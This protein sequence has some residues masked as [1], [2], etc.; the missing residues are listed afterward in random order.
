MSLQY[1]PSFISFPGRRADSVILPIEAI[2]NLLIIFALLWTSSVTA[3]FKVEDRDSWTA[4]SSQGMGTLWIY[5]AADFC[6][7]FHFPPTNSYFPILILN[8]SFAFSTVSIRVTF[9]FSN[10][11]SRSHSQIA[12]V[13]SEHIIF[14]S[15]CQVCSSFVPT[16]TEFNL[17]G[18]KMAPSEESSG[19][20][21]RWHSSSQHQLIQHHQQISSYHVIKL[22]AVEEF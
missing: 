9:S 20:L 10:I 13:S 14:L 8:I 17:S 6:T 1:S 18:I 4:H 15:W 7:L 3:L 2:P 11:I 19:Y 21:C 16:N 5:T 22:Q 12:M